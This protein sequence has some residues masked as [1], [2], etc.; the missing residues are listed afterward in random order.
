MSAGLVSTDNSPGLQMA[1]FLL[2]PHMAFAL[3]A[4]REREIPG[5]SSSS[6]KYISPI[7]LGPTLVTSFN[8]INSLKVLSPNIGILRTKASTHKFGGTQFSP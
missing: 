7:V 1:A 8:L 5:V 6:Y 4:Y 3:G 2:C